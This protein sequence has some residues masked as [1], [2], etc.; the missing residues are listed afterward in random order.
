M[1]SKIFEA[2]L[3]SA[4]DILEPI[5]AGM[6]ESPRPQKTEGVRQLMSSMVQLF[7][8]VLSLDD[9]KAVVDEID[10]EANGKGKQRVAPARRLLLPPE[11]APATRQNLGDALKDHSS[12]RHVSPA[13]SCSSH[14]SHLLPFDTATTIRVVMIVFHNVS[15]LCSVCATSRLTILHMHQAGKPRVITEMG[16]PMSW[17]L[18]DCPHFS[19]AFPK[20]SSLKFWDFEACAWKPVATKRWTWHPD[21][22]AQIFLT[23]GA[24][25]SW[26]WLGVA[27]VV[28][29][30]GNRALLE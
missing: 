15:S 30:T 3:T 14:G 24:D 5:L 25:F 11:P 23:K 28:A 7:A 16:L 8:A 2:E 20:R 21:R 17:G 1:Q 10:D 29:A 13:S 12:E 6:L 18:S 19:S 27:F 9:V 26:Y 22:Y 4:R